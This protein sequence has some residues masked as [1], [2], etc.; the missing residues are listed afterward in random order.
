MSTTTNK[1]TDTW[2]QANKKEATTAS[3]SG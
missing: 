2:P 3:Q 1:V